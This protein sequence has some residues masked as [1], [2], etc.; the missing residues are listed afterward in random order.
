MKIEIKKIFKIFIKNLRVK[1][2]KIWIILKMMIQ[3][4]LLINSLFDKKIQIEIYLRNKKDI[5]IYKN[6]DPKPHL[7]Q[8]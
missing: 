3:Q 6:K 5:K 1:R 2:I 4:K 8:L 7:I